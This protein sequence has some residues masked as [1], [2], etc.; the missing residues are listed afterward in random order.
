MERKF[1]K[2]SVLSILVSISFCVGLTSCSS[3]G[4]GTIGINPIEIENYLYGKRWTFREAYMSGSDAQYSFFRN[5]LV[6]DF[7][8][9]G[10]LVS[11][12]L[13]YGPY[14]F[15][16]TWHTAGDNLLT[17]FTVGTYKD[18]DMENLL[19]GTLTVTELASDGLQVTCKDSVGE[20]YYFDHKNDF[21]AGKTSFTDY[22]DASAHDGA[23]HGTWEMT[24]YKG[25]STPFDLTIMVDKKG[26]VRFVAESEGIDFTTTYTT[27]NGHVT[28][29]H[30]L[31]PNSPQ[32][33]FI[34]IRSDKMLEFFS[35]TNAIT[36]T[37][38]FKK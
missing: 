17:T 23:L 18:F 33:S 14:Y 15:F 13:T 8:S 37:R 2:N 6:M 29:T 35:E 26:N 30:F 19:C 32:Y 22:T 10:K 34:Y 36:I 20:T 3:D 9:P 38:W 27:K 11:G 31:T 7:R 25:D 24:A 4:D 1:F 12:M 16:C 28:F 21:G 5:H